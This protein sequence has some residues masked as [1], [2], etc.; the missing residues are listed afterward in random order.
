[1]D[2]QT[3]QA[4]VTGEAPDISHLAEFS[5]Y[6]WIKW[7]DQD[8]AM[9]EVQ[10]KYGRY[11]GPSRDVGSLMT[12]KI[13]NDKGNTL[14]HLTFRALTQ[15]ELDYKK[16][17]A[18]RDK[19]DKD[20]ERV[21]G[22]IPEDDTPEHALYEDDRVGKVETVDRDDYDEDAIDLYLKAEVTLPIAGEMK[23]GIVE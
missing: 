20:V 16:G 10:E 22:D 2:G 5:F 6:Q 21:P 17:K 3:P 8:A 14:Y 13:L 4:I 9:A 12:S 7:F 18:I 23:T 19:F 1:L 15:D 11:L